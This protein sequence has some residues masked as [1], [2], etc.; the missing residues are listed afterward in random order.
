M[1]TEKKSATSGKDYHR[2]TVRISEDEYNKLSYWA[3]HEGFSINEFVPVMLDR[4]IS[5]ENG[6]YQLPTLE[7]QRINQI[8]DVLRTL[9]HDI[10]SLTVTTTS[11]FDSLLRLTRGD[12]YLL[13]DSDEEG[14]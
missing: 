13:V 6:N 10:E 14:E 7:A 12:N 4:Y 5:I 11:G 9:S 1:A 3:Q 2:L 8:V